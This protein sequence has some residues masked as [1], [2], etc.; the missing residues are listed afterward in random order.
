MEN[1]M[2]DEKKKNIKIIGKCFYTFFQCSFCAI[3][4]YKNDYDFFF[5]PQLP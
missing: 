1:I 3:N 2:L 4:F 5:P